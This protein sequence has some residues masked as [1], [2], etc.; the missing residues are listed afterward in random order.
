MARF[1]NLGGKDEIKGI[2]DVMRWQL[3]LGPEG[4]RKTPA[5]AAV[6]WLHNDGAA[7]KN[8]G[9]PSVTWIG[10]ATFLI[11]LG[12]KSL[13]TDPILSDRIFTL[14]RN[15][16]PGLSYEALPRIDAVLLTHNHRDHMDAPTLKRLGPDVTYFVPRGLGDWFRGEGFLSVREMDWWQKADLAPLSI[17]F[18]PSQHWSR[19]GARDTNQSLWGGYVVEDS[20]QRIYHSG[21]TAY[22]EGFKEIA[23]RCGAPTAALLPIGAYEPRWFMKTQ[24]MN[25]E[26]A[27]QAFLDLQARRFVAMHWGTFKLTDEALDEPPRFLRQVWADRKLPEDRLFIPA[28]GET[29]GLQ[30]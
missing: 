28:I 20:H 8:P 22:F 21:D 26:D 2:W 11:Q 14:K 29:L 10:H 19:R 25:P 12:G 16:P 1:S 24:H 30:E 17:H 5:R 15:V 4:K 9:V 27:V 23:Q 7:L 18:V 3:G 6:P 13:L